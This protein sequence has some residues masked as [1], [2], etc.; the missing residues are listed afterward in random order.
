[1][2]AVGRWSALVLA[3]LGLVGSGGRPAHAQ[4]NC[5]VGV[6]F[7]PGGAIR[8]CNL[9]GD[10]RIHTALGQPLTCANGHVLVQYENGRLQ[11]CVLAQPL[12]SGSLR[13]PAGSRV[14]LQPDGTLARCPP[15]PGQGQGDSVWHYTL[16]RERR[17]QHANLCRDREVVLELAR[18]FRQEGPR[19]GYAALSRARGCQ[20]R[21]E[22]FTPRVVVAQVTIEAGDAS[23]Y[24]VR[25][26][27]VAT[28]AGQVEYL[29]TTRDVRP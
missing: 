7:Y 2:A 27:E 29:V 21:V 20:T 5:N 6:D 23:R 3:V 8:S 9:N 22:S 26:V 18:T 12:T 13:C 16:G 25:F 1:M 15:G 17:A 11:S 10:H 24:T 4:L 19:A 14:E 28:A